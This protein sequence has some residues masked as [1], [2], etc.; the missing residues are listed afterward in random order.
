MS[1][2]IEL[3]KEGISEEFLINSRVIFLSDFPEIP[4]NFDEDVLSIQLNFTKK[5]AETILNDRL[6][7]VLLEIPEIT[8]KDKKEII[9]FLKKNKKFSSITLK[10]FLHIALIWKA[11]GPNREAWAL[12]QIKSNEQAS[13]HED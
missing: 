9:L 2:N 10:D 13:V 6:E 7:E 1:D 5:Q 11:G 4:E 12:E 8:I 3:K